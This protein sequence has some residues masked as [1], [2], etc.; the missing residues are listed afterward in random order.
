MT[1]YF[2][3]SCLKQEFTLQTKIPYW[4]CFW[5]GWGTCWHR[6]N[7]ERECD[8][9]YLSLSDLNASPEWESTEGPFPMTLEKLSKSEMHSSTGLREVK[10][11]TNILALQWVRASLSREGLPRSCL[12]VGPGPRTTQESPTSP[13]GSLGWDLKLSLSP[14]TTLESWTGSGDSPGLQTDNSYL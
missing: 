1:S 8:A 12:I 10:L 3:L 4:S 11:K 7:V 13:S 14:R 9:W 6:I 2:S 5:G